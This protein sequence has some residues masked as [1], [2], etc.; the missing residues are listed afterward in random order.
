MIP[1]E[2]LPSLPAGSLKRVIVHWTAGGYTPGPLDLHH[3]HFLIDGDGK[4]HR[5]TFSVKDN[6]RPRGNQYAAH[7][8][9]LNTGSVGIAVC[10]MRDARERPFDAGAY[11]MKEIQWEAMAV[12][13]SEVCAAYGIPVDKEHVLG[14][15][16]VQEVLGVKQL[17]KWD[18]LGRPWEKPPIGGAGDDFRARVSLAMRL[19]LSSDS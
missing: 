18:P 19:K 15:G 5:G 7:T 8:R 4:V 1:S 14:H 17:G 12:C 2:W 10:A 16:E 9:K 3:Y 11:P 6:V 13:A